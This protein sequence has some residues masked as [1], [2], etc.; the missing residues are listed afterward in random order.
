MVKGLKGVIYEE[1]LRILGLFILEKRRPRGDL[2]AVYSFF[3]RGSGE[4]RALLSGV[5]DRT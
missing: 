2:T 1:Q 4:G 5:G 3:L